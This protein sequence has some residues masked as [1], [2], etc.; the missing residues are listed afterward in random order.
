MN[1]Q[2]MFLHSELEENLLQLLD[3]NESLYLYEDS[4][5]TGLIE[6]REIMLH[7]RHVKH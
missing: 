3:E 7:V 2:F 1:D 6:L 5:V 4:G